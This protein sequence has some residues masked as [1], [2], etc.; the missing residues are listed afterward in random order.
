MTEPSF[1]EAAITTPANDNSNNL[2]PIFLKLE[3]LRLLII[4]GGYVAFEKLGA[5]LK[6]APATQITMVSITF[7]DEIREIAGNQNRIRLVEK[8]YD[9]SDL[10]Y[11][12]IVISAVN[13]IL[14]SKRISEDT[15]AI[16]KLI[17]VADKPDL[18]DFYLGSIVKKGNLKIAISTNGKSPT[19]AKRL[20]EVLNDTLPPLLEDVLL[21]MEKIRNTLKGD[22]TSKVITLNHITRSLATQHKIIKTNPQ[23]SSQVF[24]YLLLAFALITVG[25]IL[26]FFYPPQNFFNFK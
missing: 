12:D 23:K 15:I 22:F 16:G 4:G 20:K 5:V 9:S 26:S 1:L 17:N 6:N 2:F 3:N 7:N 19:I 18:C 13:D 25:Y 24:L 11:A 14:T 21:N 8:T 10:L